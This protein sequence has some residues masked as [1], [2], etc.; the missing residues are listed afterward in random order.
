MFFVFSLI[1][2]IIFLGP[3]LLVWALYKKF[4]TTNFSLNPYLKTLTCFLLALA[5]MFILNVELEA[6]LLSGV[7]LAS[8]LSLIYSITLA[9][10]TL[11]YGL[12]KRSDNA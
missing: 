7:I 1:L 11:L 3:S 12:I 5:S 9:I 6:G 10:L 8:V 4:R 2:Q